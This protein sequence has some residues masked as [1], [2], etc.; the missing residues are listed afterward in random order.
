MNKNKKG[1]RMLLLSAI[2]AL[3][4]LLGA[5]GAESPT[6][7]TVQ[8][9]AGIVTTVGTPTV[10][11]QTCL[12]C[13]TKQAADW[14]ESRHGNLNNSPSL[15]SVG[16]CN[17]PYCHNR[18][19]DGTKVTPNRAV[20]GCESCHGPGSMHVGAGGVGPIANVA[21]LAT[22]LG[23][24]LTTTLDV[25]AQFQTCTT[26]HVLLDPTNPVS[27]TT[28]TQHSDDSAEVIYDT[29]FAVPG[30]WSSIDGSP[31]FTVI[32]GYSLQYNSETVCT[33]CHNPHKDPYENRQ[34]ADS[35][36]ADTDAS[37]AWG[38]YNWTCT[39]ATATGCGKA[40]PTINDRRQCQ[41][42]HTTTGYQAYTNALAA[43]DAGTA[44]NILWG[45]TSAVTETPG[46]KPEMLLCAGCHKDNRGTLR[47]A[48]AYSAD[49]SFGTITTGNVIARESV[50]TFNYPDITSSNVCV[51]CHSGRKSGDTIDNLGRAGASG[52][53]FVGSTVTT[54]AN[55]KFS[56]FDPHYLTAAGTVYKGTGYTF[57]RPYSTTA[58]GLGRNYG[59]P[60]SYKHDQ[61]GSS[62]VPN[63][64]TGGSC[65][66]CHMYRAGAAP[67]HLFRL[68]GKDSTG[69]I[70]SVLSEVCYNCHA[71][72]SSSLALVI[73]NERK[74]FE[75]A[76]DALT[77]ALDRANARRGTAFGASYMGNYPYM[78]K[79]RIV[80]WVTATA[81]T[82]YP[83]SSVDVTNGSAVV[84]GVGTLWST[85][86]PSVLNGGTS[87]DQF[88]T[89][90]SAEAYS[91]ASVDS[92]TQITLT[93]PY[94]GPTATL[95]PYVIFQS[96]SQSGATNWMMGETAQDR[97]RNYF[98][99]A[100]NLNLLLHEPGAYAHNSRYAKRLIYDALDWM[101][102]RS[103]NYSVGATL[104]ALPAGTVYKDE[105]MR[106]LLPAG[107]VTG[108]DIERP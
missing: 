6:G 46:F 54:F 25:S 2:A 39:G 79:Q 77:V 45:V 73:D 89:I 14:Q 22:T 48:G 32:W 7:G 53:G 106:Y 38:H 97:G 83:S 12:S 62:A 92:D 13:H 52:T 68:V 44:T 42:C 21:A 41:R 43:G 72:S 86:T 4:M 58:Y 29:H 75:A 24:T 49:Y 87:P 81:I 80:T 17:S 61:I 94:N 66:G 3:S 101:D 64:G 23:S 30:T 26:C 50:A 63:T 76:L 99:A 67:S 88:R 69:A 78:M 108:V 65:V 104:E 33:A 40:G 27:I 70:T 18:N 59:N 35:R 11:A 93:R 55:V 98:G 91:I 5:C 1:R 51:S 20:I 9:Q 31:S 100:F 82:S 16:A 107:V 28:N 37:K 71:G 34:W 85:G 36:H 10:G 15:A 19:G 47:Q 105:A 96:G 103:L 95:V 57:A 102:D 8:T 60:A 74:E 56:S 84:T 90:Y